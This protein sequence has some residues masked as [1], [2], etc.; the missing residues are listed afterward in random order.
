MAVMGMAL[1]GGVDFAGS[2]ILA[3]VAAGIV[4]G[5]IGA[6]VATPGEIIGQLS[7]P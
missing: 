6:S 5:K 3:N 7:R 4:V 1:A 2:A